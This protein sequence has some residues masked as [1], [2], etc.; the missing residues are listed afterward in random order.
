MRILISRTDSIGDVMLTLP[1]AGYLKLKH[2]N[3]EIVFIGKT[4]TEPVVNCS[5][6]VD[7][8]LNWDKLKELAE[9]DL[10]AALKS[11][12]ADVIYFALPNR[13]LA[14]AC[15]S[16]G[17]NARVGV[18]RR[19]FHWLYC[20]QRPSFSRRKSNLHEAQLNL[21]LIKELTQSEPISKEEIISFYGFKAPD[22]SNNKVVIKSDCKKVILHAKSQGSAVEWGLENFNS[23]AKSLASKNVAI[24][25]TGTEGEGELIR[26]EV[27]FSGNVFDLTGKMSLNELI[28]FIAECDVLVAA[29]T[30]PLHIAAALGVGALGLYSS[31]RPIHPGRWAPIGKKANYLVTQTDEQALSEISVDQVKAEVLRLID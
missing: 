25:F 20:N 27:N 26:K 19:W 31:K 21:K 23:L 15:K 2:P 13:Q 5:K 4:Y 7:S 17:I 29:S 24:F 28:A 8:F 14:K 30:G 3:S 1:M 18:S 22:L 12:N 11:L 10:V 6:N 9:H 16:A